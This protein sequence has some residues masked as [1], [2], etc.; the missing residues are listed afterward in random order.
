MNNKIVGNCH[1]CGK[2]DSL[3]SAS[4][5]CVSCYD[6]EVSYAIMLK[7]GDHSEE[8]REYLDNGKKPVL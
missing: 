6:P 5:L 7:Y 2:E 4:G 3:D 8:L 1:R